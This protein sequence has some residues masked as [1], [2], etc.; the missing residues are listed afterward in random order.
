MGSQL[1]TM[2]QSAAVLAAHGCLCLESDAVGYLLSCICIR[3]EEP[4]WPTTPLCTAAAE[5]L[6]SQQM[7]SHTL[8]ALYCQ[9][10]CI[11]IDRPWT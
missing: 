4:G 3:P 5:E 1:E 7:T 11:L 8:L 6:H 9:L 10:F 2:A